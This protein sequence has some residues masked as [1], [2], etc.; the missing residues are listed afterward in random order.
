MFYFVKSLVIWRKEIW[1]LFL[2][3]PKRKKFQKFRMENFVMQKSY[4]RQIFLPQLQKG[5]QDL[6][7]VAATLLT[8]PKPVNLTEVP[9]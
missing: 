4:C 5:L 2:E 9:R 7:T 3:I 6:S 1:E 8:G